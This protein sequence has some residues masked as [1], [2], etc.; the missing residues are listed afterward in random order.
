MVVPGLQEKNKKVYFPPE[1][2][3]K[4]AH[5]PDFNSYLAMY[6]RSTEDPEEFW[7]EVAQEFYWK[8][9]PTG[10]MLQY[11]FDMTK[12]QVYI[13]FME[14]AKTNMCYNVLDRNV[15]DRHLGEKVAYLW[16]G[17]LPDHHLTITYSQLL[18]EV[19]RC[20]N[21]L[22]QLGIKK[23]D[24]VA[25]YLPMIPELV[26]TMLACAR[27]GAVHSIVVRVH[28]KLCD[29]QQV[30]FGTWHSIAVACFLFS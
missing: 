5:V 12:D 30:L 29:L 9:P 1:G 26:F 27:I 7:R 24:R 23:G 22:K 2:M 13:K 4:V 6:K 11:N 14:G 28:Q 10:Q 25:I 15:L 3:Q 20:A 17:N 18:K 19:C 8:K 21:A 16:E